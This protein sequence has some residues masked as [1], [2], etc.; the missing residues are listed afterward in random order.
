MLFNDISAY[1]VPAI[2]GSQ[3]TGLCSFGGELSSWR[4]GSERIKLAR[5]VVLA[6]GQRATT[7]I[8]RSRGQRR[9]FPPSRVR[10]I[11]WRRD[12]LVDKFW[13][14]RWGQFFIGI[15]VFYHRLDGTGLLH[16]AKNFS[17]CKYQILVSKI[18]IFIIAKE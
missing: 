3:F 15:E 9:G 13:I 2:P 10:I 11:G 5:N 17:R 14:G 18:I 16:S 8:G 6:G 7:P 12:K 4:A 1:Q